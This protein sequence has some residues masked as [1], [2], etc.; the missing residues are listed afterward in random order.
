[1]AVIVLVSAA[2]SPGV[3]TTAVAMALSWPRPVL[4]VEADPTGGNAVL[5]GYLRGTRPYDGGMVELALSPL[6]VAEALPG[7]V[8]PLGGTASLLAGIRS[9]HQAAAARPVWAPLTA[10][11]LELESTGQDVIVDAGRLGLAGSPTALIGTGDLT[12]LMTRATLPA[13]AAA[14]SWARAASH[15]ETGWRHPGLLLVAAGQPYPTAQ[16]AEVLELPVVAGLPDDAKSAAVYHRGAAPPRH[17]TAGTYS[18]AVTATVQ[19][20]RAAVD[21]DRVELTEGAER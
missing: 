21:R 14:R 20:V 19:A 9:H 3:T 18:R 4:L 11:L 17:F 13:V 8:R 5:A 2:G 16:I 15:P 10:A 1:M 12:L 6:E 7:Q